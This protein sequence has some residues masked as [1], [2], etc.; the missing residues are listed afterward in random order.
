MKVLHLCSAYTQ[1]NLYRELT[2]ALD[3]TGISQAVYVPIKRK[4]DYNKKIL[5]DTRN[6][7]F[8]YSKIFNDFDRFLYYR[9]INKLL[10]DIKTK[11]DFDL[12]N[13]VHAHT[14][15]SMGG[16]A[17]K[18]KREN[19]TEYIVAVRST[20]V[21]LFF[22]YLFYLRGIGIKILKESKKIIFLSP[23]YRDYV[24]EN[25][26]PGNLHD[27]I[28]KKSVIVPNGIDPFFLK[29][30][31]NRLELRDKN[32]I[33]LIYVGSFLKRK[34]IDI[35]VAV[36]KIL[37]S[38]GYNIKLFIV[39]GNGKDE[40]KIR[41]LAKENESIIEIYNRIREKEKLLDMYKKAD[42]FIMPSRNE[43]FGLVYIEA[44]SQGLPVIYS[45]GQGIDGYFKDGRIG[46]SVNPS[47]VND[48]VKKIEMIIYN[49][50][51][52]SNNCLNLVEKFSWEK[53]AQ[54]YHKI[55]ISSS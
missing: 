10:A 54:T 35:S 8:I 13:I 31:Y 55:Y 1:S 46:Y 25:I 30:K 52:I 49:Y 29:N 51:E 37:K 20:D 33:K 41:E 14:L 15:F 7:A 40:Y 39:G 47:D 44:M 36:A 26:M 12:I 27:S 28:R 22:K 19:N 32:N 53:I 23:S 4:Q 45:K 34:N 17:L 24:L 2:E 48:I 6:I 11:L 16:I 5:K 43:T 3:K 9:K 42:I 50:N 21:N 38:L 18:L